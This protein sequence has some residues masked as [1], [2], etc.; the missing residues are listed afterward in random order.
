MLIKEQAR[1]NL[2]MLIDTCIRKG[3]IFDDAA[4]VTAMI[5]SVNVLSTPDAATGMAVVKSAGEQIQD[6][7]NNLEQ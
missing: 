2:L 4:T 7:I 5:A 6:R 3:G 1:K